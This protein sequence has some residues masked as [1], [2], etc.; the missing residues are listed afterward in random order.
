MII[1][2]SGDSV[3]YDDVMHAF[4]QIDRLLFEASIFS[5]CKDK[6]PTYEGDPEKHLEKITKLGKATPEGDTISN[7]FVGP[8]DIESNNCKEYT[9]TEKFND[10][11]IIEIFQTVKMIIRDDWSSLDL[12][13]IEKSQ[14]VL[15]RFLRIFKKEIH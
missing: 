1:A 3:R 12:S 10:S 13:K 9:I 6:K 4:M 8:I 2:M 15:L 5:V 14:E 11:D 7:K